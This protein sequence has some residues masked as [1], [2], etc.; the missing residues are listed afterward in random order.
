VIDLSAGE[1]IL[2]FSTRGFGS[3]VTVVPMPSAP[4]KAKAAGGK[5]T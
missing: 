2:S 4:P 3:P 5:Q 1:P